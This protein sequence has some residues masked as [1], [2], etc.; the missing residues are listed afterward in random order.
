MTLQFQMKWQPE[1]NDAEH[2]ISKACE[3]LD[4]RK[5]QLKDDTVNRAVVAAILACRRGPFEVRYTTLPKGIREAV[6]EAVECLCGEVL[7]TR[8]GTTTYE[9]K[10][11]Y[12]APTA[13]FITAPVVDDKSRPLP[14]VSTVYGTIY[15]DGSHSEVP[16]EDIA[17]IGFVKPSLVEI[18]APHHHWGMFVGDTPVPSRQWKEL[19]EVTTPHPDHD[20][21][22]DLVRDTAHRRGIVVHRYREAGFLANNP[23]AVGFIL[24]EVLTRFTGKAGQRPLLNTTD[25]YGRKHVRWGMKQ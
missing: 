8:P 23:D 21:I 9:L 1:G 2:L 11:A 24:D 16:F 19:D 10:P 13:K 15:R 3:H 22:M 17:L 18:V 25:I 5:K 20:T 7:Y 6:R 4:K 14:K 12:S